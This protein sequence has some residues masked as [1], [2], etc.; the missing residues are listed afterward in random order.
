MDLAEKRKGEQLSLRID[1][2]VERRERSDSYQGFWVLL[3]YTSGMSL[4]K[5][6]HD[7]QKKKRE[8]K[9]KKRGSLGTGAGTVVS[10]VHLEG[11]LVDSSCGETA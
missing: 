2:S 10:C 6:Q 3:S 4:V 9:G 11:G 7:K 8:E 5:K 1:E